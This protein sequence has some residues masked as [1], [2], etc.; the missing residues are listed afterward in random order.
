MLKV[1]FEVDV[2]EVEV[3]SVISYY[4]GALAMDPLHR[5]II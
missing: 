5:E 1:L 2:E 4:G 3:F